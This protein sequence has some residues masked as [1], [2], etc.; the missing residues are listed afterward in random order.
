[1]EKQTVAVFVDEAN[2]RK[3]AKAFSRKVDWVVLRDY[4]A[5]EDEGRFLTEFIVYY[6]LA[7][8]MENYR[9]F[10]EGQERFI[11][12]LRT[13]GFYVVTKEGT[14]TGE[15][16][17]GH[18]GFKANVDV[19]MAID[20]LD[21]AIE[22]RPDIIVLV[23][24]D[25]DFAQLASKLRRRG[26]RVEVASVAQTLSAQLKAAANG[27]I[28]LAEMFNRFAPLNGQAPPIGTNTV[29]DTQ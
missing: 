20:G 14:P 4:L 12:W 24:G 3:S 2:V 19:L 17:N 29:F 18:S 16:N 15:S 26:I 5:N 21:Y 11:H 23:T 9:G 25:S 28:D 22:V 13:E 27:T 6:G 8:N 10:R 1:M 7:P